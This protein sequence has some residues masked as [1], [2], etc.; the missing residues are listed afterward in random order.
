LSLRGDAV[1]YIRENL[2]ALGCLSSE[3][4]KKVPNGTWVR[5]AGKVFVR[6]R[7]GTAKGVCFISLED[8]F[9]ISNL[10]AW[11]TI[12]ERFRKPI[13]NAQLLM[14]EGPLQIEQGVV[15]I[16]VKR[17]FDISHL[18]RKL[19]PS[20]STATIAVQPSRADSK[21]DPQPRSPKVEAPVHSLVQGE[22]FA[23]ARNY[24]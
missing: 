13:N 14:V 8:E 4:I 7:P 12:Y 9:G 1:Q 15:H 10:I 3:D 17:C 19:I 21:S 18:F 22:L 11:K 6:Q 2:L 5:H 16:I 20:G 23:K 24:K